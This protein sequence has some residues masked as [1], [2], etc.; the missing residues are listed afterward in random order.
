MSEE[1]T[2]TDVV[3]DLRDLVQSPG[4]LALMTQVDLEWGP[5]GYGKR[6]Q[7][8]IAR[9][10]S[11]PDRAYELARVV[12]ETDAIAHAVQAIVQW[13]KQQI[14]RLDQQQPSAGIFSHLRRIAR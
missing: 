4:W 3:K 13:P 9:V 11:G 7:E 12:E 10:P 1:P 6:M 8:A 2:A 5:T 14:Q